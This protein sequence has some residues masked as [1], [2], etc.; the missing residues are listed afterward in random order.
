MPRAWEIAALGI[1]EALQSLSSDAYGVTPAVA[2]G[3]RVPPLAT[4]DPSKRYLFQLATIDVDVDNMIQLVGWRQL[5]TIG[6]NLTG[7]SGATVLPIEMEVQTP[8]WRFT[9]GNVS[10]HLVGEPHAATTGKV[11]AANFSTGPCKGSALLYSSASFSAGNADLN[12]NP[13]FYPV[14]MT[15]YAPPTGIVQTWEDIVGLN[16]VHDL[17]SPWRDSPIWHS[18]NVTVRGPRRLSLYASVAQTNPGTRLAM[19]FPTGEPD[20]ETTPEEYFV[21]QYA[22]AAGGGTGVQYWRVGGSLLIEDV[23][24]HEGN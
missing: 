8:F 18:L 11:T 7:S 13:F 21:K 5:V 6:I 14:G 4:T 1:D 23:T 16:N 20:N 2:T 24:D 12:G 3:L 17:R 22:A 15:A 10:F 9:D 19:T